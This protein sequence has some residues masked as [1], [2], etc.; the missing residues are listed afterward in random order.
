MEGCI[1]SSH[2]L[3][4]REVLAHLT[5]NENFRIRLHFEMGDEGVVVDGSSVNFI[6]KIDLPLTLKLF[7]NDKIKTNTDREIVLSSKF[8]F[9]VNENFLMMESTRTIYPESNGLSR[10]VVV[11][12]IKRSEIEESIEP[13]LY[14]Y[15]LKRHNEQ[16]KLISITSGNSQML[17]S[18]P[19]PFT[20]FFSEVRSSISDLELMLREEHEIDPS[21]SLA[22]SE[23]TA[24]KLS[25]ERKGYQIIQKLHERDM[26]EEEVKAQ[27]RVVAESAARVE[28][29]LAD[30]AKIRG[31]KDSKNDVAF[32]FS[33]I[34]LAVAIIGAIIKGK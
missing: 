33:L 29:E 28:Q 15:I 16:N 23:L 5:Q 2:P 8:L 17:S 10:S 22:S 32:A 21:I 12:A 26:L 31:T 11:V 19:I 24:L 1:E 4:P 9:N 6:P 3:P 18:F 34:P 14:N 27:S 13:I 25:L 30:P 7:Q 20:E